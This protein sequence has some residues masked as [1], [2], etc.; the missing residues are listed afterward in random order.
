MTAA[1]ALTSVSKHYGRGES[2][3]RALGNVSLEFPSGSFTAIMGPSGSGKT[4]LLQCAAGLDRPDADSELEDGAQVQWVVAALM[5]LMAAMAVF[6][7]GAMAAA[8][9]RPELVLA[10]LDG[11]TR[12]QITRAQIIKALATTAVGVAGGVAI[13]TAS[14]AGIGNDSQAGSL[15]IPLGQTASV[16]A[17]GTALGLLGTLLPAALVGRA[18][19][20]ANAG[21]RE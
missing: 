2:A 9:R 16:L 4:T 14:L 7:S 18:R 1:I 5:L 3:V 15:V 13:V 19:L 20:T 17:L 10:R 6:N 11:A 12:H 8:Q 21:L